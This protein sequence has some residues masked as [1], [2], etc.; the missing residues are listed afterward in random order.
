M[1]YASFRQIVL[2][3]LE[4]ARQ[5]ESRERI[6]T[7][8]YKKRICRIAIN[9]GS[10]RKGYDIFMHD[11]LRRANSK[12]PF[13]T[14]FSDIVRIGCALAAS[15]QEASNGILSTHGFDEKTGA[16]KESELPE[17]YRNQ[18]AEVIRIDPV[19]ILKANNIEIQYHFTDE[20]EM[21][22]IGEILGYSEPDAKGFQSQKKDRTRNRAVL[23]KDLIPQ[24]CANYILWRES[25]DLDEGCKARTGVE[26][27]YDMMQVA[28]FFID[29]V[30]VAKQEETHVK[31]GRKEEKKG[32]E[33][34]G[35]WN[36]RI[37]WDND[38]S[39]VISCSDIDEMMKQTKAFLLE[40]G[41]ISR[42]FIFII[43]GEQRIFT[44]IES[45]FGKW[46]HK[47]HLDFSHAVKKIHDLLS[48]AIISKRVIDP[49]GETEYYVSGPKKGQAR[50]Q[51]MTSLSML[52]FRGAVQRLWMGNPTELRSYI[53][54]IRP[55][56]IAYPNY[57][58]NLLTYFSDE[59][60][61]RY[62]TAY[63]MRQI[64]GLRN[65]SNASEGVNNQIVAS[66]QKVGNKT[67][68]QDGSYALAALKAAEVNNEMN[69]Y[70]DTGTTT[71]KHGID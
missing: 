37:E 43:D 66:I 51:P 71:F 35:H 5:Y 39:Y 1:E 41:L 38:K 21:P 12:L 61:G 63:V 60:K 54:H 55:E 56:H 20:D 7:N 29:A 10:Y 50:K 28:Y 22:D 47:I 30:Y 45:H 36:I 26:L 65:S 31:G 2:I 23:S 17:E 67:Y 14:Y 46:E 19:K 58:D 15:K 9:A 3:P 4:L 6:L 44:A 59:R 33:R 24:R 34:I 40:N 42:Y 53:K 32:K 70:L 16:Y 57:I 68:G 27:E 48:N 69:I 64:V 62:I 11:E 52:Y 49:Q 8:G 25:L 18:K 13:S